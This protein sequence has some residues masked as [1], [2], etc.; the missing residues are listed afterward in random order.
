MKVLV[1]LGEPFYSDRRY[2]WGF[3][4]NL[5]FVKKT[6]PDMH[7]VAA[8]P[9]LGFKHKDALAMSEIDIGSFFPLQPY[10]S[11]F[12]FFRKFVLD[13]KFRDCYTKGL[14]EIIEKTQCDIIWVRSPSLGAILM[15]LAGCRKSLHVIN[16][17]CASHLNAHREI[18]YQS[19]HLKVGA[20]LGSVVISFLFKRL[21]PDERT[22]TLATGS[23]MFGFAKKIC[24]ERSF[25]F[26]D[27]FYEQE[28]KPPTVR[29]SDD[30]FR[31]CFVGRLT[32]DKGIFLLVKAL[33]R[34]KFKFICEV[35]GDGPALGELKNIVS[36]SEIS[37][38]VVLRG[39]MTSSNIARELASADLACVPSVNFY[40]G[41]PRVILEA[42]AAGK[43]VVAANVGGVSQLVENRKNGL[44][45]ER[46]DTKAL[47]LALELASDP[48]VY[49]QLVRGVFDMQKY[50]DTDFWTRLA[51]KCLRDS[52]G[53]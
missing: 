36:K 50:C 41:F 39:R 26:V 2:G 30:A 27:F 46:G 44:L 29:R 5:E 38:H 14:T 48:E 51:R 16:H 1:C 28:S 24:A 20:F 21:I 6:F 13:R 4:S 40:E 18:K 17:I 52:V 53:I 43:P 19:L 33:E 23:E 37:D 7:V 8:A 3:P 31:I 49:A 32:S 45:F 12:E 25:H 42:W 15:G 9:W 35:I 11:Q 22:V 47:I 10:S 34:V